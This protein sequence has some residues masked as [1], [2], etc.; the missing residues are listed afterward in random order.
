MKTLLSIVVVIGLVFFESGCNKTSEVTLNEKLDTS[1]ALILQGTFT[2]SGSEKVTGFAKIY[3]QKGK[4]FL[5]LE[6]FSTSNGPDLKVYLSQDAPPK[7]F[8]KLSDLKS[9]NGD[10]LYEIEGMPDFTKYKYALIHCEKFNH[11]YG[12]AELKK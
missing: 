11:L 6:N 4:Y 5:A 8:M 9:T 2:G 10:Q 7:N 1:A 12:S 3:Q